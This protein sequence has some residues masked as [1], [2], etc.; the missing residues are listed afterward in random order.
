M[1]V[2][3]NENI[4]ESN[5]NSREDHVNFTMLQQ[6]SAE[7]QQIRSPEP[8]PNSNYPS[9]AVGDPGSR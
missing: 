1:V 2:V 7:M 4:Q 3:T 5:G 6:S 8:T 9:T